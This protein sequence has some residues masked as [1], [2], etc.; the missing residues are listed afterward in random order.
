MRHSHL[1]KRRSTRHGRSILN[2]APAVFVLLVLVYL[3]MVEPVVA[4]N[5][6]SVAVS[7]VADFG[8][9]HRIQAMLREGLLER[10][11][12]MRELGAQHPK[13]KI[14]NAEL[15][16][17]AELYSMNMAELL[18][19]ARQPPP[20]G[21]PIKATKFRLF[22]SSSEEALRQN[23]VARK[24]MI[25]RLGA[26]H[27]TVKKIDANIKVLEKQVAADRKIFSRVAGGAKSELNPDPITD[28][29]REY[30]Q[31]EL[32]SIKWAQRVAAS[33]ME[34][35]M[36]MGTDGRAPLTALRQAVTRAFETRIK[37]QQAQLDAA[38]AKLN[39]G[40]KRLI[41]RAKRS[42]QIIK[43]RMAEL[44]G[45]EK[46]RP[47]DGL[48]AS[49][50]T[51]SRELLTNRVA[52]S[53]VST[54]SGEQ[55]PS[56]G[57]DFIDGRWMPTVDDTPARAIIQF[58]PITPDHLGTHKIVGQAK[59]IARIQGRWRVT[60]MSIDGMDTV[61]E[62]NVDI[63]FVHGLLN[64]EGLSGLY[65][66]NEK[67]RV[68]SHPNKPNGF[69]FFDSSRPG[70]TV[71][72]GV[73]CFEVSGDKLRI[74]VDKT[75]DLQPLPPL[76]PAPGVVYLECDRLPG[77]L[78]GEW[79]E[80]A[81]WQDGRSRPALGH[82]L[83]DA[84]MTVS[85]NDR[86]SEYQFDTSKTPEGMG[87]FDTPQGTFGIDTNLFPAR[88]ILRNKEPS[89]SKEGIFKYEDDVLVLVL[90]N[91]FPTDF[92]PKIGNEVF[93]FKR[94]ANS[95]AK[96]VQ[97]IA[98]L[99]DMVSLDGQVSKAEVIEFRIV[100][101]AKHHP[102]QVTA[103]R[104]VAASDDPDERQQI[105]IK[106]DAGKV[107]ARWV[108]VALSTNDDAKDKKGG[109][110][111][112]PTQQNIVRETD[113]HMILDLDFFVFDDVFDQQQFK[114]WLKKRHITKLEVLVI[115]P[116]VDQNVTGRDLATVSAGTDPNSGANIEFELT[117]EGAAKMKSLTG[118]HLGQQLGIILDGQLNS[119]PTI[120]NAFSKNGVISGNFTESEVADMVQRLGKQ[121][122][123]EDPAQEVRE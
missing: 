108:S 106:N 47:D 9:D 67:L 49:P 104:A 22:K 101:H 116:A 39:A 111:W 24:T 72:L 71:H 57:L 60:S 76:K 31:A 35:D 114:K 18:Q 89:K 112:L 27:P 86:D 103:A 34:S 82:N 59:P 85:F 119:A 20:D 53:D 58:H 45:E 66:I 56:Y 41:D 75:P 42:E 84:R 96:A 28:L 14:A 4:Q 105:N 33:D 46:V 19:L 81:H 5:A 51:K 25:N 95:A 93:H 37:L 32:D 74:A 1:I 99:E 61:V 52:D 91:E 29:Q 50:L 110:E 6:G 102:S 62:G 98:P 122:A 78:D 90:A 40:R 48:R 69:M 15:K 64:V 87:G 70:K 13:V 80:I 88:I 68:Y 113:N 109:F 43:R 117:A 36:D 44:I 94:L 65:K 17:M 100:A 30:D 2:F 8:N 63:S 16:A 115:K 54:V 21:D 123:V 55:P 79:E 121:I 3:P 77:I 10:N 12:L 120:H 118:Q 11:K 107:V 38:E 83:P 97:R 73:G 92:Q 7:E 23:R 26:G